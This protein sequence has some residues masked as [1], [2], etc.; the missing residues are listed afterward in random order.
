MLGDEQQLKTLQERGRSL[1][2]QQASGG[3]GRRRREGHRK[4]VPNLNGL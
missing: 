1:Q 4:G 3:C 2:G